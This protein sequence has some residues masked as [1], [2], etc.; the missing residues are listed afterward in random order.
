MADMR[1]T[2]IVKSPTR[3]TADGTG[4]YP[5]RGT[6]T[7]EGFFADYITSLA[8]QGRVFTGAPG[9]ANNTAIT[10]VATSFSATTPD[11]TLEA[12]TGT[13]VIP[14]SV[15]LVQTGSVAGGF[16]T[17][18]LAYQNAAER[19]S[20]GTAFPNVLSTRTDKPYATLATA[21]TAPTVSSDTIGVRLDSATINAN[22]GSASATNLSPLD[23]HWT[24]DARVP[25]FLVGPAA[26]KIYTWAG[27]TAPTWFP[28]LVWAEIPSTDIT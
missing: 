8:M 22:I 2:P 25:I 7:G 17:V 9:A 13:T 26:L 4:F 19:S 15:K 12:P 27:T 23:Y 24:Y 21:Y 16:I 3:L 5:L 1:I 11:F 20:S 6:R 14:L 18:L 28:T 10:G